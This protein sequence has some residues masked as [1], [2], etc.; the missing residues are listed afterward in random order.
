M[1]S[2]AYLE[3]RILSADPVELINIFYEYAILY[4]QEARD[5]LA[6]RDIAARSNAIVKA[7]RIVS[8]LE[9]ALDHSA[10]GEIATNLARLYTYIRSRLMT[11]NVRQQDAPLAE[12]ESLLKTLAKGWQGVSAASGIRPEPA[13]DMAAVRWGG[14]AFSTDTLSTGGVH[15]W[16][17]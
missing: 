9:A 11:A 4:V 7:I 1:N 2:K 8:E 10:G 17:F 3:T 6:R 12:V 13:E 16:S 15:S 5:N 14:G